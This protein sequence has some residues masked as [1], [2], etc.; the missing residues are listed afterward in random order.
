RA[1]NILGSAG[2]PGFP[3]ASS[4][5]E[6]GHN[7]LYRGISMVSFVDGRGEASPSRTAGGSEMAEARSRHRPAVRPEG[8]GSSCGRLGREPHAFHLRRVPATAFG[9][10]GVSVPL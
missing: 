10:G 2:N 8:M 5:N 4:A 9:Q 3:I 6:H 1:G 7:D